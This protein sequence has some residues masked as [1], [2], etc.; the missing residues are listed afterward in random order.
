VRNC[1]LLPA[2][3][4]LLPKYCLRN[5]RNLVQMPISFRFWTILLLW[6]LTFLGG[7]ATNVTFRV[8]MSSLSAIDTSGIHIVGSLNNWNPAATLVDSV[9]PGHFAVTLSL[10]AGSVATYKFVNGNAWGQAEGVFGG[11]AFNTYRYLDVPANDT[12][13][14]W[15]CF[16]FCDS[17]CTPAAG[18]RIAC[19]GNSITWGWDLPDKIT[20]SYPSIVQDRLGP[21]FRVENFGA[22]GAAVIRQA[23]NPYH[24]TESFRHL[25]RF[26]PR[27]AVIS[28]GINDSKSAIWGNYGPDF[29]ADYDTLWR[30]LDT[31]PSLERIWICT[32]TTPFSGLFG[33]DSAVLRQNIVPAIRNHARLHCLDLIDL[34]SFTAQMDSLFP[35]GLHPDTAATR[36]IANEV[37]RLMQMPRPQI[38]QN[39][40]TLNANGGYAWQWYFNGDTLATIWGGRSQSLSFVP[41]G[42]YKVGVQV[43]SLLAHVLISDSLVI[44]A[45]HLEDAMPSQLVLFPDPTSQVLNWKLPK[46][47]A[48]Y[49]TV[50]VYSIAGKLE[51][52]SVV[53]GT[54]GRM[55]IAMLQKGNYVFELRGDGVLLREIFTKI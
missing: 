47:V 4:Y 1:Y 23:G 14:A 39:G 2:T 8:D 19:V 36:L 5:F 48:G 42:T 9:S 33:I 28:L 25:M 43:D 32:P 18:A 52:E 55:D 46:L 6:L 38:V 41:S 27:E 45:A 13:L 3:Y 30:S 40:Q 54:M 17:L 53:V 26:A 29:V 50:R 44:L 16:G 49:L 21:T 15:V 12:V 24:R 22:P 7:R 51:M 10:P 35:D 37:L 11:C 34:H 31:M 20:Q